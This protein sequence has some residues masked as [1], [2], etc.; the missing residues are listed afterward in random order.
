MILYTYSGTPPHERMLDAVLDGYG[1]FQVGG[2]WFEL[3][4]WCFVPEVDAFRWT[5]RL[6]AIAGDA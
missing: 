3:L 6:A 2:S 1:F 5:A 4:T